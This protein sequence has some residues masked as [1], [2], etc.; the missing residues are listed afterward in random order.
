MTSL[1]YL[2]VYEITVRWNYEMLYLHLKVM[3]FIH[4]CS[5]VAFCSL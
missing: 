1:V 2:S 5:V 3:N 4:W